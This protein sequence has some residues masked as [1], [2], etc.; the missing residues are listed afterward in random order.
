MR[1]RVLALLAFAAAALVAADTPSFGDVKVKLSFEHAPTYRTRTGGVI[2]GGGLFDNEQYLAVEAE[3]SP[4]IV[5]KL[6]KSR[7]RSSSAVQAKNGEWLDGVKMIVLVAYPEIAGRTRK[8]TI[9]GLF[10][11]TTTFWS[12]PLDGKKHYATMFVPPHLLARYTNIRAKSPK[13]ND[14]KQTKS[15]Y[16]LSAR[17]FFAEVVFTTPSGLELGRG[18]CN[19]DGARSINEKDA[20]F[21]RL[22]NQVGKRKIND[23]V[24]PRNRSPWSLINPERFD[25][26]APSGAYMQIMK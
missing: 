2:N 20:Y 22:E 7:N 19:V 8:E 14:G 25:L 24:F 26:I 11:G 23:A 15:N 10:A 1:K 16:R 12:I 3:F 18:Y 17:D 5:K 13:K 21:R 6:A 4:G 9:Y